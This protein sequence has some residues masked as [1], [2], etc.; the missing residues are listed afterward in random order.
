MLCDATS[1]SHKEQSLPSTCYVLYG[2]RCRHNVCATWQNIVLVAFYRFAFAFPRSPRRTSYTARHR[3]HTTVLLWI[4]TRRGVAATCWLC[5]KTYSSLSAPNS[6]SLIGS[7]MES[8]KFSHQ[9]PDVLPLYCI[10]DK[11]GF[12]YTNRE[13][14]NSDV[15]NVIKGWSLRYLFM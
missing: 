8:S 10:D 12:S 14:L 5:N 3:L 7:K 4:L 13:R 11:A 9:V 1:R 2:L 6:A 15:N